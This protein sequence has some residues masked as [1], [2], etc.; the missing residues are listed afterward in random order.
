MVYHPGQI[1]NG[2]YRIEERLGQG[3]FSEAYRVTHLP[4]QTQRTLKILRMGIPGLGSDGFKGFGQHFQLE[5]AIDQKLETGGALANI[6]RVYH[7]ADIDGL[8]AS[9]RE[10]AP[11]GSL[12]DVFLQNR[13][14]GKLLAA[15]KIV[16]V[17]LEI[18]EGLAGLHTRDIVHRDVKPSNILF[19]TAN[20]LKISDL[21]LAQVSTGNGLHA[22]ASASLPFSGPFGYMSPEQERAHGKITPAADIYS[23]GMILFELLTGYNS[24]KLP[25]GTTAASI[26]KDTPAW[27]DE[28]IAR[29]LNKDPTHRPHDGATAAA[30]LR[31]GLNNEMTASP[32]DFVDLA[33]FKENRTFYS[34]PAQA[35]PQPAQE[36]LDRGLNTPVTIN[37][38]PKQV[39]KQ[40]FWQLLLALFRTLSRNPVFIITSLILLIVVGWVIYQ[41]IK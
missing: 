11:R 29:M 2:I 7:V 16:R 24:G 6:I 10:F 35:E 13:A 36:P 5:Q 12:Y 38:P 25:P 8:P 4:Q 37:Q 33:E 14:S 9:E 26:R 15:P 18:A 31:A 19:D 23:L 41:A 17:G 32:G 20:H 30:L 27:L 28:L 22:Q 40:S 34:V 3:A 39:E 1:I 21:Y